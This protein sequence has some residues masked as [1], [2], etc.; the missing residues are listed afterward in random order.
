MGFDTST[1]RGAP[2]N[3]S[4]SNDVSMV[5]RVIAYSLLMGMVIV[6]VFVVRDL[7]MVQ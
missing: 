3:I 1:I 5:I 7:W 4:E 6:M 2:M